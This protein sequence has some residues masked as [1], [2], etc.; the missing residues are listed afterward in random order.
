MSA[1]SHIAVCS[2]IVR[3][4]Q[5]PIRC[6]RSCVRRTKAALSGP[7]GSPISR[8]PSISKLIRV[9]PGVAVIIWPLS[10]SGP[11]AGQ[12]VTFDERFALRSPGLHERRTRCS[13][14]EVDILQGPFSKTDVVGPWAANGSSPRRTG[15]RAR[16]SSL[17]EIGLPLVYVGD[18][19]LLVVSPPGTSG[20]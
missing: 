12:S 10:Q 1:A 19:H 3:S 5:L 7:G 14:R 17:M 16:A 9:R 8:V 18:H 15:V 2:R 20:R 11:V 6:P 13:W 4:E